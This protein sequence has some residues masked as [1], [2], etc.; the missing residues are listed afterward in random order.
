MKPPY[1]SLRF[2]WLPWLLSVPALILIAA[3]LYT[4]GAGHLEH[5]TLFSALS[6]A[7]YDGSPLNVALFASLRHL[8]LVV[9]FALLFI[10][11]LGLPMLLLAQMPGWRMIAAALT[12]IAALPALIWSLWLAGIVSNLALPEQIL[13]LG[14]LLESAS[15]SALV[16]AAPLAIVVLWWAQRE[17]RSIGD[18]LAVRTARARGVGLLAVGKREV[19]PRLSSRARPAAAASVPALLMLSEGTAM[20]FDGVCLGNLLLGSTLA[21]ATGS[22]MAALLAIALIALLLS[23]VLTA[24]AAWIGQSGGLD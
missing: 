15:I 18:G 13:P 7:L 20:I 4:F 6:L 3:M 22:A 10:A 8:L 1:D 11:M 23:M 17:A 12:L 9:M 21:S 5:E 16:A 24:L 19:L 14:I 2:S